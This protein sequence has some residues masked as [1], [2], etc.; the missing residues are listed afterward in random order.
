M[1]TSYTLRAIAGRWLTMLSLCLCL[2]AALA[3]PAA[4]PVTL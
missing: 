4:E 2:L 1:P 3:S